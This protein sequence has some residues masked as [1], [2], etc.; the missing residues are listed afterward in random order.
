MRMST[1]KGKVVMEVGDG[2]PFLFF[3][4]KINDLA[5]NLVCSHYK[6]SGL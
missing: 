2:D 1:L 4:L 5:Q 3:C 6:R